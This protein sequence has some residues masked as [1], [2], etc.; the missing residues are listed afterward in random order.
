[1]YVNNHLNDN[2]DDLP[3]DGYEML[4]T[5]QQIYC[6]NDDIIERFNNGLIIGIYMNQ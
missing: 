3:F 6:I 5:R 4:I 2:F 1:M